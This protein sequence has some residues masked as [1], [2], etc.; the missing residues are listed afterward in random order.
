MTA[1]TS[2]ELIYT[3]NL[4]LETQQN[5]TVPHQEGIIPGR[6]KITL[7][8]YKHGELKQFAFFLPQ[9]STKTYGPGQLIYLAEEHFLDPHGAIRPLRQLRVRYFETSERDS[10]SIFPVNA[11]S[12]AFTQ[13]L[14]SVEQVFERM[15]YHLA[16]SSDDD[17]YVWVML[18]LRLK[19]PYLIGVDA[20]KVVSGLSLT[21]IE[22]Y[23]DEL[24]VSR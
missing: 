9:D 1:W 11:A 10:L 20:L 12:I 14:E 4:M 15:G 2:K 21:R 8:A 19:Y 23:P 13:L 3:S 7:L 6:Q 24:L 22:L 5:A 17:F 18:R 16:L